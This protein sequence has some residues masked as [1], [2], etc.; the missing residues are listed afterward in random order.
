[1]RVVI[2][3]AGDLATGIALRLR[4]A[5][6]QIVMLETPQPTAIRRT[7]AMSEAVR[8]GEMRVEDM[9]GV[10]C[11]DAAAAERAIA[12]RDI[13]VCVNP[14][15]ENLAQYK[16]DVLVDA[17]IAKRNFGTRKDMA[18]HVIALGPGFAAGIDCHAVVETMRGHDLGRVF[19]L[20]GARAKA[21]TKVPGEIAGYTH[22]RVMHTPCAGLYE[23]VREIADVVKAGEVVAYVEGRPVLAKID[24]MLRG[25]LPAGL[26]TREHMKCADVDPR[27]ERIHCFTVSDKA[28]CLGGAVLEAILH[29][30]R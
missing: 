13:A 16:T 18:P 5:N 1:M 12:N 9:R 28:R 23:P 8:K 2:R 14:E 6:M 15:A 7:V 27:C 4:R 25:Q 20:E 11:E 22:E 24:G 21:D 29:L 19:Y 30:T 3:G 26:M 10:Y 17:I